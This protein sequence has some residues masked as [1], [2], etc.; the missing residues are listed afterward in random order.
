MQRDLLKAI[1]TS[2]L[3]GEI[4]SETFRL[5]LG[6]MVIVELTDEKLLIELAMAIDHSKAKGD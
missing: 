5:R 1:A 2:Y 4:T 6:L 3:M